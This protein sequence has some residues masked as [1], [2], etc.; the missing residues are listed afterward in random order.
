M[1]E[2]RDELFHY[3]VVLQALAFPQHNEFDHRVSE[4]KLIPLILEP[5]NGLKTFLRLLDSLAVSRYLHKTLDLL[6]KAFLAM[7]FDP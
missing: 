3:C 4:N 6:D 2:K 7:L 5:S 1:I